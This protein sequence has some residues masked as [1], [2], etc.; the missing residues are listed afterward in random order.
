MGIKISRVH[1]EIVGNCNLR[2]VYCY[3][4]DFQEK[5]VEWL[6]K[7][8]LIDFI[9]QINRCNPEMYTISGGEP[10]LRSDLEEI[11][12]YCKSQIILFTNAT[13]FTKSRINSLL[14]IPHLQGFRISLDGFSAHNKY[15]V[16][17]KYS[18]IL[19]WIEY[20]SG[21]TTK[22]I[23]VATM[24]SQEGVS[25]LNSLYE[26]LKHFRLK[27]WRIDIPFFTGRYRNSKNI[28]KQADFL[29][30]ILAVRDLIIK[31]KKD[32]PKFELG[33][34]T[35]YKSDIDYSQMFNFTSRDHPCEYNRYAICLRPNGDLSFCPSLNLVFGNIKKEGNFINLIKQI[36]AKNNFY[37][38]K[39][40][41]LKDCLG[42]RYLNICGG[43]CRADALYLM[44]DLV[45][46][47]SV[48]CSLLPLV[49]KHI[50]PILDEKERL[51]FLS[52]VNKKG[53]VPSGEFNISKYYT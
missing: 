32:K 4:A 6:S 44:G 52:L 27:H 43:G 48:N 13:L 53:F 49:E 18:D 25:E 40:S 22:D 36:R 15:R 7:S 17:S 33:I 45:K 50:L 8:L 37:K 29:N 24:L 41:Q 2:C 28:F 12:S 38:I 30:I 5:K 11:L 26:T 3:N 42:C 21:N 35:I 20:L 16:P 19:N 1:I 46:R 39:I 47:D 31:Y 10:L 51:G 34:A 23:G 9:N 14:T